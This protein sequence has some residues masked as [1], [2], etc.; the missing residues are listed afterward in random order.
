VASAIAQA[1]RSGLPDRL[2]QVIEILYKTIYYQ[3]N[4]L[5]LQDHNKTEPGQPASC[6][7]PPACGEHFQDF[8][9]LSQASPLGRM[10]RMGR[11]LAPAAL[12]N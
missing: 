3:A 9:P 10:R 5:T 6:G 4:I 1:F 8:P 2:N 11:E 7:I 12:I